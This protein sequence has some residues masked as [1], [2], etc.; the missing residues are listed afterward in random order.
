MESFHAAFP[1]TRFVRSFEYTLSPVLLLFLFE[2]QTDSQHLWHRGIPAL[3]WQ[4][5]VDLFKF[6]ELVGTIN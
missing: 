5:Q 3:L 2:S 6:R 4:L 1:Y